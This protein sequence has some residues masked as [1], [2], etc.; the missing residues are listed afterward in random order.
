MKKRNIKKALTV[1]QSMA[2]ETLKRRRKAA[3]ARK[4]ALAK[5]PSVV[6]RS[7]VATTKGVKA[8]APVSA[9]T[10][11]VLIAEG[12][13]WF[14]YPLH[15]VLSDLE[16]LHGYDVESVARKG[17][18]VEDMAYSDGQLDSFARRVEKVL[19]TGVK[20]KAILVSGGGND[21]AGD[22]FAILLNHATSS[23]AGLNASIVTGIIDEHVHDAYVTILKAITFVCES[24]IGEAV[25][26]L[27]HGYDYPVP[28][29]RGFLGGWGPLPGPWF[30]PGFR[31]KGYQAMKSRMSIVAELIVRF[32]AMLESVAGR[33]PF[34][35]VRYVNLRK[36][37]STGSDYEEWW[38]NELHPTRKGF[39]AVTAKFAAAL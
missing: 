9:A 22:E 26:I 10:A 12:D 14:D 17:D 3:A 13:S 19:R 2:Q 20:P 24:L 5:S 31:R 37:L 18:N 39:E 27:I 15:D 34:T 29:G 32:N 4:R 23:I 6:M 30:E 36:T 28:D 1:G 35:H 33:T 8:K 7:I 11:G 16:D 25:P 21:I 38:A